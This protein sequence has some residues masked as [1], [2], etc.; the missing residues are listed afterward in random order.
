MESLE[1]SDTRDDIGAGA[2]LRKLKVKR[3]FSGTRARMSLR[4]DGIAGRAMRS[5]VGESE[6]DQA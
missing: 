2:P 5:V 1:Q 4:D 6:P 3:R